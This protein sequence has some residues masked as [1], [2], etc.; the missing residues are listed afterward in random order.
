[1]YRYFD[2]VMNLANVLAFIVL[3]LILVDRGLMSA[4]SK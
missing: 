4:K 3:V 2:D 1:M